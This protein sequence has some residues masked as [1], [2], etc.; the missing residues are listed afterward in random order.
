MQ[1]QGC[2]SPLPALAE[3]LPGVSHQDAA[4]SSCCRLPAPT[5]P[6][7]HCSSPESPARPG[8]EQDCVLYFLRDGARQSQPTAAPQPQFFS[9][10]PQSAALRARSQQQ[11]QQ[12]LRVLP[13]G[14]SL[15]TNAH[16]GPEKTLYFFSFW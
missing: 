11:Q 8:P 6:S 14:Y 7:P 4:S 3:G 15:Y 16:K 2:S 13:S 10:L 12:Q 9:Q 1:S 5:R